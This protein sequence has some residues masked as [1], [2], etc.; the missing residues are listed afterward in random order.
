MGTGPFSP[1][2]E[3]GEWNELIL[4]LYSWSGHCKKQSSVINSRRG[5]FGEALG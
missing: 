4:A 5:E 3:L 2:L 1:S